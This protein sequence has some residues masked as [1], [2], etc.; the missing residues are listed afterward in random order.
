VALLEINEKGGMREVRDLPYRTEFDDKW[1]QFS[2]EEQQAIDED[3]TRALDELVASGH[4]RRWG[5]IMNTSIQ[6]GRVNPYNG[7]WLSSRFFIVI[8]LAEIPSI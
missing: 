6:G 1:R 4:S 5:S 3:I 8:G 7:Q 2:A